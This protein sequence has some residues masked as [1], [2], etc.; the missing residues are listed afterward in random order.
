SMIAIMALLVPFTGS[1]AATAMKIPA[2]STVA[3]TSSGSKAGTSSVSTARAT[4][5]APARASAIKSVMG[6]VSNSKI[7][8]MNS[9]VFAKMPADYVTSAELE[10]LRNLIFSLQSDLDKI[11]SAAGLEDIANLSG[12]EGPSGPQG[13]QGPQGPKG[14]K[15]DTGPQ[16]EPGICMCE[17]DKL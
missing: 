5:A 16:G 10:D 13:I 1:M 9:G 2:S 6:T 14:E 4:T 17:C 12:P 8:A 11:A 15:G 7:N 3:S